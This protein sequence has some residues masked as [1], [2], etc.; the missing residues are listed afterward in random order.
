MTAAAMTPEQWA[1]VEDVFCEAIEAAPPDV[2]AL[3]NDRLGDEPALLREVR[4]LLDAHERTGGLPL[5]EED[6]RFQGR[7][8]ARIHHS[9][10]VRLLGEGGMGLVFLAIREAD[11]F[12]QTVALKVIRTRFVDPLLARRFEEERRILATLEHPGIA[13]LIDGGVTDQ[14][15]PYIAMEY[16]EG[17]SLLKVCDQRRMGLRDHI[18]L[19][20]RV[21]EAVH[22]AHL[23]LSLIHI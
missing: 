8:P 3:L 1:R 18:A 4:S 19:F 22:A 12:E 13:L 6:D 23:R 14:G 21:C 2:A 15:E 10:I 9:R 20:I 17:G 5:A 11:G 16:V 7:S